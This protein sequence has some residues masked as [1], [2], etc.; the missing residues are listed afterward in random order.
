MKVNKLLLLILF[1]LT[2]I[3][4]S[5]LGVNVFNKRIVEFEEIIVEA[6]CYQPVVGQCDS[7]PLV[8]ASGKIINAG[9]PFKHR[10]IVVS[11]DLKK[12]LKWEDSVIVSGTLLYD[13][14]WYVQDVM[15]KRFKK[16]IDFLIGLQNKG[17]SWKNVKI[18][19]KK[20]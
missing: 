16:K 4:I 15:N 14:I 5:T 8:T 6:S 1:V 19:I 12:E 7:S 11:R 17:R 9:D 3:V 18:Q 20:Q 2:P 13:G 10:W